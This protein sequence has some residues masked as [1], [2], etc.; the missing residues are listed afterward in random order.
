MHIDLST[1]FVA[2]LA[3]VP[4][5]ITAIAGLIVAIRN[6]SKADKLQ[7]RSDQTHSLVNSNNDRLTKQLEVANDRIARLESSL[8]TVV[9][10][11]KHN[12]SVIT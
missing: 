1:V 2:F 6:S 11:G 10:M 4:V 7:E 12:V 9:E 5:T 3:A 8:A